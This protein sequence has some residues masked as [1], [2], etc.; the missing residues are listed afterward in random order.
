VQ[1]C[2]DLTNGKAVSRAAHIRKFKIIAED[3]SIPGGELT[4]TLKLK[5]SVTAKKYQKLLDEIFA[6]DPKL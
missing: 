4:P 6:P 2:I 5:R 1:K 3:F